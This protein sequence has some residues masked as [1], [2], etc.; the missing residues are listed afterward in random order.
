MTPGRNPGARCGRGVLHPSRGGSLMDDPSM[1]R[2]WPA[3]LLGMILLVAAVERYVDRHSLDFANVAAA[4]WGS[5]ESLARKA[6]GCEVLCL[7]SSLTT[8]GVLPRILE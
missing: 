4:N 3:G 2:G 1:S 5:A 6:R 8:N 7:G